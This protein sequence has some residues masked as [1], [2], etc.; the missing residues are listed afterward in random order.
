MSVKAYFARLAVPAC[1]VNVH[2]QNLERSIVGYRTSFVRGREGINSNLTEQVIGTSDGVDPLNLRL[3]PR[4]ITVG[5]GLT[6]DT[7]EEHAKLYSQLKYILREKEIDFVFEDDNRHYYIGTVTS[8]TSEQLNTAGT[9]VYSSVGEITIRCSK[10]IRYS[11]DEASISPTLDNGTTFFV[12]YDGTYPTK[13]IIET[14]F[15]SECG[16]VAFINQEG[17]ILQFGS[18]EEVDVEHFESSKTLIDVN[19]HTVA[20]L[21][22]WTQNNAT[23]VRVSNE[24]R[25]T[26]SAR[27][28]QV[29][30]NDSRIMLHANNYGSGNAWHGP[31]ITHKVPP[32]KKCTL[33]WQH[34]F[35]IGGVGDHGVAQL[36]MTD[37]N[38]KNVAALSFF[39]NQG[40][41]SYGRSELYVQGKAIKNVIHPPLH[42]NSPV[43][44]YDRGR[45]SISKFEDKIE[46]NISGTI[47][48]FLI[49][50]LKDV[51]VVE[52]SAYLGKWGNNTEM[53][54]NC[55]RS[56]R[57]TSHSV[58]VW[59][60]VPNKF[61][62]NDLLSIDC[63]TRGI[64]ING[65][66]QN[67]L[68]SL[69]NDWED[70]YL[71]HGVNEI[72]CVHSTWAQ[73]PDWR[74][75]YRKAWL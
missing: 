74:M 21:N 22:G 15:R 66:V 23:T 28:G 62:R 33:A 40:G 46:F 34:Y 57:F 25:Q 64:S 50:E 4:E 26:G 17:K 44:G 47:H 48:S 60:D 29:W 59:R 9:D 30:P 58:K 37:K 61:Q 7:R 39:K 5:Y 52:I 12:N 6:T 43:T 24:H 35:A 3:E 27:V 53:S 11:M 71:S 38:G 31:S 13:P 54:A 70:F 55:L 10:P 63:A 36:L 49:P 69:G 51:E 16:Y 2:G 14:T 32:D 56:I 73:Q 45:S 72:R 1:S 42:Y 18:P 41:V 67:R 8:V 20:N 75:K 68:A 65:V 19:F